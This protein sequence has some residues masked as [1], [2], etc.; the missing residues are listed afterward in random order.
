MFTFRSLRF[1]NLFS[2]LVLLL[3]IY[4]CN[5]HTKNLEVKY[6]DILDGSSATWDVIDYH[7][8][9]SP[10]RAKFGKGK[11]SMRFTDE[12]LS[13]FLSY[14]VYVVINNQNEIAVQKHDSKSLGGAKVNIANIDI[15]TIESIPYINSDGGSI[16]YNQI[17][18]IYMRVVW[19]DIEG[20]NRTEDI[21]LYE[22]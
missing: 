13:D 10:T 6:E 11:L 21:I 3:I 18:K 12:Y 17:S 1:I 4:G 15:G 8:E 14:E 20:N 2:L 9:M 19:H 22:K 7:V 16:L 5:E